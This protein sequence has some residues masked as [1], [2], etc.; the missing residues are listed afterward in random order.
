M[1]DNM[2]ERDLVSWNSMIDGYGMH[3]CSKDAFVVFHQM[4]QMGVKPDHITFTC[5]LSACSHAGLVDLGWKC[6]YCLSQDYG[7]THRM[8][9]YAC[10]VDILGRAGHLDEAQNFI[11][12]MPIE[13]DS[14]VWNALLGACKI[15][16]NVELGEWASE[17]LFELGSKNT[18]NYVLLSNL[19]AAAGRWNDV[20]KVRTMLKHRGLKK[21]PGCS[22]IEINKRVHA[23]V[24]ADR[25]HPQSEKIYM[26]LESLVRQMK[27]AGYVPDT[28][29]VLHD[30]S[31]EEK[32]SLV[33]SHS[34]KLAIAFGLINTSPGMPIQITKNLRVCSDC[35]IATKFISKIVRREIILRDTKRFHYFRDGLCSCGDYW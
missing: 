2:S 10:M 21:I 15:H 33:L 28:S 4:Q 23:F 14:S 11:K 5:L 13:P 29:F 17:R 24:A 18:G 1:F 19:Y 7:I 25:S 9:H 26:V 30:V 16:C 31:E 27:V 34:E 3:G 22:W 12:M 20:A 6:F 8:E 32:K 35:H